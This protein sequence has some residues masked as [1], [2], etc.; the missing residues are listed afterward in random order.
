MEVLLIY[1]Y[2]NTHSHAYG[3]IKY[4]IENAVRDNDGVDYY[5]IL[6]NVDNKTVNEN[7][8][9]KLPKRNA[10][11]IQHENTCFDFGTIG[12]F[13]ETYTVGNPWINRTATTIDR[14]K[15]ID[16]ARYKY[17]I[18]INS[19]VRGP[20][21]PPYFL[22]FL[23][24]DKDKSF[25]WYH[26]FTKRLN[27]KIK[28]VGPTISCIP[29]PHVQS[30]FFATDF[31]GLTVLLQPGAHGASGP[32]R[33]FGCFTIKIHVSFNSEV[34]SSNRILGSGYLIDSLMTKYQKVN[35]KE[36]HNQ[37]CNQH[38]NPYLDNNLEGTSLEPYELV[39]IKYNDMVYLQIPKSRG[40]LYERWMNDRKKPNRSSW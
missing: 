35:F 9:P 22:K 1:V 8:M 14:G 6:Q 40:E 5:F 39:F 28:L 4:F 24:D 23:S 16:L 32:E 13:F 19:S 7:E 2:S 3:N 38:R 31:V 12:W 15:R 33:I 29:V 26:V 18:F 36:S 30:Y 27:D 11:Y 21:F 25:Y 10:R 37:L 20:F 17:F 34:P